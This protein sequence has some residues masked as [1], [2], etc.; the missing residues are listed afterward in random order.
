MWGR[1]YHPASKQN[2]ATSLGWC[3]WKSLWFYFKN[4]LFIILCAELLINS[5]CFESIAFC[6]H[7]AVENPCISRSVSKA[8]CKVVAFFR[9][10]NAAFKKDFVSG[11]RFRLSNIVFPPCFICIVYRF[12]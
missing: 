11:V 5:C 1:V 7:N 6:A 8:A 9:L 2:K 4:F 12:L 3:L 10:L